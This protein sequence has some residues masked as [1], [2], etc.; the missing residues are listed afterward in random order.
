MYRS[1]RNGTHGTPRTS[2]VP[3]ITRLPGSAL[4]GQTCYLQYFSRLPAP[5]HPCPRGRY[6]LRIVQVLLSKLR[7]TLRLDID[8]IPRS[9]TVN[10]GYGGIRY[11]N[12]AS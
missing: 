3:P 12:T 9:P 8:P 1:R 10:Q 11:G 2:D 4:W 5:F 6:S 7:M